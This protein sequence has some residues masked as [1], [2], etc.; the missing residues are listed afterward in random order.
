VIA[1]MFFWARSG[2]P[3]M[4]YAVPSHLVHGS[5]S[6]PLD[7]V[8]VVDATTLVFR[9]AG[10]SAGRVDFVMSV[11]PKGPYWEPDLPDVILGRRLVTRELGAEADAFPVRQHIGYVSQERR[12]VQVRGLHSDCLKRYDYWRRRPA[13]LLHSGGCV[14][15]LE[16]DSAS[17]EVLDFRWGTVGP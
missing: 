14:F 17:G 1:V 2:I 4:A 5:E 15:V 3:A 6:F 7:L 12:V 16:F 13:E 8:R 11:L 9:I 10:L